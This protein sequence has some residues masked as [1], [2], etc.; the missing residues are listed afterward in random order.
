MKWE[1]QWE[2]SSEMETVLGC[3]LVDRTAPEHRDASHLT[4]LQFKRNPPCSHLPLQGPV[5]GT[6]PGPRQFPLHRVL[7]QWPCYL[8]PNSPS[9]LAV[10]SQ[11]STDHLHSAPRK[12]RVTFTKGYK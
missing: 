6:L 12:K 11:L 7:P 5:P 2:I 1:M 9:R 10:L 4:F 3:S 8:L